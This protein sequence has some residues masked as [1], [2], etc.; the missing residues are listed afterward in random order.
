MGLADGGFGIV[1][2]RHSTQFTAHRGGVLFRPGLLQDHGRLSTIPWLQ[3]INKAGKIF[4]IAASS[5]GKQN[6][7]G[8]WKTVRSSANH[9][10]NKC[11]AGENV[12]QAERTRRKVADLSARYVEI[13]R[14]RERRVP[15]LAAQMTFLNGL[16]GSTARCRQFFFSPNLKV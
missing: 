2:R 14:R 6:P 1:G 7:L 4:Q 11:F 13:R 12:K 3:N 10:L 8:P 9:L 5:N 16:L 15:P